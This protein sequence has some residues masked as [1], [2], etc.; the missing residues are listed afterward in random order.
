MAG[1]GSLKRLQKEYHVLSK[2][3]LPFPVRVDSLW[4]DSIYV[5]TS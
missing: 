5:G 2:M 1:K 3:S 4:F